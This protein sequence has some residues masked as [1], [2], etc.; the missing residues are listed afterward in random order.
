M[1]VAEEADVLPSRFL[2]RCAKAQTFFFLG[3]EVPFPRRTD[4]MEQE[5]ELSPMLKFAQQ[6]QN[7]TVS[8][9]WGRLQQGFVLLEGRALSTSAWIEL[10]KFV[11]TFDLDNLINLNSVQSCTFFLLL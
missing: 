2:L 9:I 8:S 1:E 3:S 10:Y 7:E 6:M 5:E 11:L 4:N